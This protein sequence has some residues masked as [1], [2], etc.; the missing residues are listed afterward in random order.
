MKKWMNALVFTLSFVV[1]FLV[2]T[3]VAFGQT[4]GRTNIVPEINLN[5]LGNY[6]GQYATVIYA[7]GRPAV[8]TSSSPIQKQ[9]VLRSVSFTATKPI[10]A[11]GV[12]FPKT[13]IS[14]VGFI[15]YNMIVFVVHREPQFTWVN[16]NGTVPEGVKAPENGAVR[17]NNI[18]V[19]YIYRDEA[20]QR[21]TIYTFGTERDENSRLIPR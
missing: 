20:S 3:S 16:A 11:D 4:V 12:V 18:L 8:I 17:N 14:N 10:S 19:D 7:N 6:R 5:G 15:T 13:D 2:L 9:V 1:T 21:S